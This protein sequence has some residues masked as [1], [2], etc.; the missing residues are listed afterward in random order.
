ML[1]SILGTSW[2]AVLMVSEDCAANPSVSVYR[3]FEGTNFVLFL[4][5]R[6]SLPNLSISV[7]R[8]LYNRSSNLC[9]N[10]GKIRWEGS[11][12]GLASCLTYIDYQLFDANIIIPVTL[13]LLLVS[14]QLVPL[15]LIVKKPFNQKNGLIL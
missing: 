6:E 10:L 9:P 5:L 15:E 7:L 13:K 1:D 2:Y 4:I 12:K 11:L 14:L 8:N 3:C